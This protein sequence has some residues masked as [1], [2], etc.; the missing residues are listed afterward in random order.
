VLE[1]LTGVAD[2]K[3]KQS[4]DQLFIDLSP[5]GPNVIFKEQ[6]T[7][8]KNAIEHE[9]HISFTYSTTHGRITRRLLEPHTLVQK[10]KVW[11]VYGYC[12]LREDFRLFKISRMKDIKEEKTTFQRKEVNLSE[13]P[14]DKK[15]HRPQNIV[16]LTLSFDSAITTLVE[17]SFGAEHVDNESSTINISLPEDEW[18]Y[19]FL[20]SFGHRLKV[21]E[22]SHIS[23]IVLKR[24][25]EIVELY[26]NN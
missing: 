12:T 20:L 6:I 25:Q 3:V 8:L 4:I 16:N 2:E 9:H 24:A 18:L 23:E 19:G 26:K 1:K 14:W 22:P 21:L 5:W 10:G 17:E 7:L 11:Y 15:W 13:L